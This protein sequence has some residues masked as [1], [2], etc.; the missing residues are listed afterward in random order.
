MVQGLEH[1]SY[2]DSTREEMARGGLI[3]VCKSHVGWRWSQA[4][5]GCTQRQWHPLPM[6]LLLPPPT[7]AGFNVETVEY[8]NICFTVWDVGGQD[9]IRPLWR[10]YFQNT[11]V[12]GVRAGIN[13]ISRSGASPGLPR[14]L[15][16]DPA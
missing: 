10:H 4:L 3:H 9:K 5:L 16:P 2:E 8:K 11:Q 1:L 13:F 7:P 12:R 14:G 6:P 15:W